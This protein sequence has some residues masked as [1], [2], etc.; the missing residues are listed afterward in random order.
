[1][2]AVDAQ[3]T[4]SGHIRSLY[5]AADGTLTEGTG[6][7]FVERALAEPDGLL[8][9]DLHV[10]SEADGVFLDEVVHF[11]PLTIEDSVT[12]RVDPAKID[13]YGEYV[14]IVVQALQRYEAGREL[15]SSEADFYLGQNYVVSIHL[16]EVPAIESFFK[17]CQRDDRLISRGPDWVLSTRSMRKS[18]RSRSKSYAAPTRLRFSR[19]C[20]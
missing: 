9:V 16:D 8:W 12:P 1:M 18:M 13:D 19:S 4:K 2:S 5:R 11:H 14:F 10:A 3:L 17:Q 6:R 20:W 7:E 15:Q